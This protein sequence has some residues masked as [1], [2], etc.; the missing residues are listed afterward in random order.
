M[1]LGSLAYSST[2][3]DLGAYN[4]QYASLPIISSSNDQKCDSSFCKATIECDS[5]AGKIKLNALCNTI[6][7]TSTCPEMDDCLE[8]DLSLLPYEP[9]DNIQEGL[10]NV[11]TMSEILILRIC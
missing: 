7:N 4:C 1:I 5:R 8:S 10:K 2:K 3:V 6:K 11:A 9:V